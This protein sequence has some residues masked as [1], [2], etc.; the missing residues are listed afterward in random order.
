MFEGKY[1]KLSFGKGTFASACQIGKHNNVPDSAFDPRELA[2]GIKS[3]LEHTNDPRIAKNIA[4][5]HLIEKRNYYTLL[6]K[7]G[8]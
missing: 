8:L 7:A 4:R 1:G 3:E 6:M 5:D 2:L